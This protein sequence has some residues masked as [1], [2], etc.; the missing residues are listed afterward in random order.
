MS[1]APGPDKGTQQV[2]ID[3]FRAED[4]PWITKLFREV[5]GEGYPIRTYYLPEELIEE[6]AAGRVISSVARTLTG[7]VVGHNALVLLDPANQVYENAAGVVLPAFRG[8]RIFPRLFRH[9]LFDVSKRFGIETITGEPVCS[10]PHLQRMCL[11]DIGFTELGL[12]VE[13]M[14]AAAYTKDQNVSGRVSVVMGCFIYK[15]TAQTAYIPPIYRDQLE[16]LYTDIKKGERA[17]IHSASGLPAERSTR[18]N[19]KLFALA[20]VVRI[21]IEGIGSD[22]ESFIS[23]LENEAQEKGTEVF[24]AWLPLASPFAP[25]ATDI[26]R[27]HGY[28]LGGILPCLAGGDGLLMQKLSH[29]PNWEGMVLYSDRAKKM[30]EMVRHDWKSVTGG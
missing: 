27:G 18:A 22:F 16:Y 15:S 9:S 23:L 21:Y 4:A 12:E 1:Y 24:Q 7:E 19:T 14:P 2:E 17:F 29:A 8:Y 20:Q 3:F 5:Y 13:L 26:L 25:A 11:L 10:H 28:F 6:N 30:G